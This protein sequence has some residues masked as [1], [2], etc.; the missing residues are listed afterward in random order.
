[1]TNTDKENILKP[2]SGRTLTGEV[3]SCDM[4]KTIVVK[5]NRLFKHPL[6][7]K[8]ITRSKNFKAHDEKSEAKVGDTVEVVECRPISKTKHM[9][10]NCVLRRAV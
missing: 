7:G 1:M 4:Q 10:L 3:I 2:S 5:V 6:L 8:T 9:I